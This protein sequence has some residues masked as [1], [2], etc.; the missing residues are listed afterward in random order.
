VHLVGFITRMTTSV[1][2]VMAQTVSRRLLTAEAWVRS[3]VIPCGICG[4][5][6]GTGTDFYIIT[7]VHPLT[8]VPLLYERYIVCV[9]Q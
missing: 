1:G 9:L 8:T 4:G 2:S 5:Q 7:P 3:Q 6:G